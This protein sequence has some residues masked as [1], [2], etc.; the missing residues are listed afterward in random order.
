MSPCLIE[1]DH[2]FPHSFQCGRHICQSP[3]KIPQK[4]LQ[5]LSCGVKLPL[6]WQST[7]LPSS[8]SSLVGV[9]QLSIK[10]IRQERAAFSVWREKETFRYRRQKSALT[11]RVQT[12]TCA[13]K[14]DMKVALSDK[15]AHC[16]RSKCV[17]PDSNPK[18]EYF[19]DVVSARTTMTFAASELKAS[20]PGGLDVHFTPSV[21]SRRSR[22]RGVT[23]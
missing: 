2:S 1:R 8:L 11:F 18:H 9:R 14:L 6:K 3:I 13:C 22:L 20:Q 7:I 15:I 10:Q 19:F 5:L 17:T 4:L 12:R 21:L 23:S 16:I